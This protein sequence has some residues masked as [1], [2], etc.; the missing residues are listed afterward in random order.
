MAHRDR[1]SGY[2]LNE[3]LITVPANSVASI[4]VA[5]QQTQ[6]IAARSGFSMRVLSL[7]AT[8][9]S[10]EAGSLQKLIFQSIGAATS[11]LTGT[12]YVPAAGITWG[13]NPN[14]WFQGAS[15]AAVFFSAQFASGSLQ[16][17]ACCIPN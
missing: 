3:G 6:L 9:G 7:A 10:V 5:Q 17:S 2:E 8:S 4:T 16:V 14:G 1:D 15:G 12:L 13:Y 11:A